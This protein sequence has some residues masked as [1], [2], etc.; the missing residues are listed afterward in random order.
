MN[1]GMSISRL[2]KAVGRIGF[3]QLNDLIRGSSSEQ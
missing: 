1:G 2:E 3:K